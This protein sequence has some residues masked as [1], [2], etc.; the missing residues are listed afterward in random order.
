MKNL[1]LAIDDNVLDE[2][3]EVAA[4][5]RTTVNALVRDF[6]TQVAAEEGKIAQARKELRELMDNSTARLG[7][8]YRWNREELYADRMFPRHQRPHV[9]GDGE[10]G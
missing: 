5:R 4:R 2:V 7:P 1:T 3:R 8:G 10:T 6:L 9:R